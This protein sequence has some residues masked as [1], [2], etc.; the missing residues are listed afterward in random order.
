MQRSAT[1]DVNRSLIRQTRA[2]MDAVLLFNGFRLAKSRFV[3]RRFA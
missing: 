3:G 2:R 1:I